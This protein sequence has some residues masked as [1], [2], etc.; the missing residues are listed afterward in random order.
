MFI[1]FNLN[2]FD[3]VNIT[4]NTIFTIIILFKC[5]K[6]IN[7]KCNWRNTVTIKEIIKSIRKCA[8]F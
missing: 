4:H 5:A 3:Q 7:N 8:Y 1:F 2:W 6:P